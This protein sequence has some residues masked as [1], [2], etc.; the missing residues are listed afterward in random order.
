MRSQNKIYPFAEFPPKPEEPSNKVHLDDY[1]DA[2]EESVFPSHYRASHC[3]S[4]VAP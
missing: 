1:A 4:G 2:M 3:N